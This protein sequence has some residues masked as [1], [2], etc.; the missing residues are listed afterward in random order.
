VRS[1]KS[2]QLASE[3]LGE[4]SIKTKNYQLGA[5][6]FDPINR[7]VHEQPHKLKTPDEVRREPKSLLIYKKAKQVQSKKELYVGMYENYAYPYW[8]PADEGA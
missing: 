3:L 5:S 8:V 4:E 6:I 1:P 7:S 2:C